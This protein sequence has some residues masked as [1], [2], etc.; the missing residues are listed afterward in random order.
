MAAS[1]MSVR[2]AMISSTS[3]VP[4]SIRRHVSAFAMIA[5]S[6]WR[7]SCAIDA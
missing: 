7:T 5:V 4:R 6:G 1:T 3:G 2:A